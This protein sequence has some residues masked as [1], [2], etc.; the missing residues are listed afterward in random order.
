MKIEPIGRLREAGL[1]ASPHAV[2]VDN[3][4]DGPGDRTSG[5]AGSYLGQRVHRGSRVRVRRSTSAVAG[6]CGCAAVASCAA[7]L[8]GCA[9]GWAGCASRGGGRATAS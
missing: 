4:H 1:A 7:C 6:R 9:A 8:A 3:R 5:P 2:V